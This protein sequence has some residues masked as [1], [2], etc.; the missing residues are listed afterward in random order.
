M[1]RKKKKKKTKQ[2]KKQEKTNNDKHKNTKTVSKKKKT[3]NEKKI[4]KP[5]RIRKRVISESDS[6]SSETSDS[7]DSDRSSPVHVADSAIESRYDEPSSTSHLIDAWEHEHVVKEKWVVGGGTPPQRQYLIAWKNCWLLP[8][9]VTK[10]RKNITKILYRGAHCSLVDW[11]NSWEEADVVDSEAPEV[12]STWKAYCVG[13]DNT[14][15]S[16]NKII[17]YIGPFIC[18]VCHR[19]FK[20]RSGLGSHSRVHGVPKAAC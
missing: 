3:A 8:S 16:P 15:A 14:L 1:I 2:T 10:H 4:V 20:T 7:A 18:S 19:A 9:T 17:K 11:K 12:T 13:L 5:T 6:T